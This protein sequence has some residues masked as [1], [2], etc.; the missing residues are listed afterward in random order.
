M[1]FNHPPE[2]QHSQLKAALI[3]LAQLRQLLPLMI[4]AKSSVVAFYRNPT[5]SP[6]STS[7]G[8]APTADEI[9]E[10]VRGYE[11]SYDIQGT[12]PEDFGLR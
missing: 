4:I 1:I 9:G 10:R 12:H 6:A 11:C 5:D 3:F 8:Y 7:F 2:S